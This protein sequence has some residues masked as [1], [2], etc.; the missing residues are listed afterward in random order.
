MD[1]KETVPVG[2]YWSEWSRCLTASYQRDQLYRM[3]QF[4]DCSKQW[5][6]VKTAMRAKFIKNEQEAKELLETTFYYQRRNVSPTAGVI[7]ELKETPGWELP[8]TANK[9]TQ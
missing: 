4:D 2:S 7:W 3:G 6:D 1:P 8:S 9:N 5:Q